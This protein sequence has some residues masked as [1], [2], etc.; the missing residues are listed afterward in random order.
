[1][2][3]AVLHPGSVGWNPKPAFGV[4]PAPGGVDRML[5]KQWIDAAKDGNVGGVATPSPGGCQMCYMDHTGCHQQVFLAVIRGCTHS[6][7]V[8][9]VLHG[10]Y[11]LSS[12]ECD[13]DHTPY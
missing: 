13:F 7:G 1:M 2:Q 6:R 3:P 5:G 11:W 9:D 8:S 12:V 10:P 4:I